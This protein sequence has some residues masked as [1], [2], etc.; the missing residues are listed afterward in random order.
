LDFHTVELRNAEKDA[1]GKKQEV[2]LLNQQILKL[3]NDVAKLKGEYIENTPVES[4]SKWDDL[5]R[6]YL[7][8]FSIRVENADSKREEHE[9]IEEFKNKLKDNHIIFHDRM[10]NAF[11]TG[12]KVADASPLVV[13]AGISGTGKSL[14]PRLYA[15]ALGMNFLQLA[16]QPRWDNP[17]DMFGF[18]NYMERRYKATELSRLLWQ[19][20]IYNNEEAKKQYKQDFLPMNLILLDEMNIAKVE[21]YFSDM[22]SKLEACRGITETDE[23][24]RRNAEIEIESGA[25]LKDGKPRRLYI[26]RNTLFVG[27]MNEDESTQS[28]SDK[29]IDRSNVLRFGKPN[30]I[31]V[32]PE[33]Q[34]FEQAYSDVEYIDFATWK[35]WHRHEENGTGKNQSIDDD[36]TKINDA[37]VEL[38]R[39]F[40]YR[41]SAA[42]KSY[43]NNYPGTYKEALADQIEMKILPKLNGVNKEN[44]GKDKF[45]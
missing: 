24:S 26:G 16:V 18:Y 25:V 28:L 11:H 42:I 35:R 29:V 22:L 39:P 14:L 43:A 31:K 13:L 20:D 4:K 34:R 3:K 15:K 12:L 38:G 7:S 9:W 21:Y 6:K 5:D 1:D 8:D 37:L 45:K 41:T 19:F 27:T 32:T 33:I 30:N 10:L 40:G 44:I 23:D 17:Q 2:G 36:I